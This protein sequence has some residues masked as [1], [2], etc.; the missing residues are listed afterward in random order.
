[1]I[2][3]Q[4]DTKVTMNM[5]K[6]AMID[7]FISLNMPRERLPDDEPCTAIV[8]YMAPGGARG[9][10]FPGQVVDFDNTNRKMRKTKKRLLKKG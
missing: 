10:D 3:R 5:R 9:A 7:H 8:P 6:S 2:L 4:Y 1:M